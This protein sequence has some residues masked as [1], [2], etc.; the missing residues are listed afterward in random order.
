MF[1]LLDPFNECR[2]YRAGIY[3]YRRTFE[4]TRR[5]VFKDKM[6]VKAHLSSE[7]AGPWLDNADD[8]NIWVTSNGSSPALKTYIPQ[9]KYG[10][11]LLLATKRGATQLV[12]WGQ[13]V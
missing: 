1:N 11:V 5:D 4:T 6:R 12:A 7:K 13:L 8:T 3:G 9:S 10:F 2:N